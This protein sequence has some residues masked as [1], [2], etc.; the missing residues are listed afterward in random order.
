MGAIGTP[1]L[2]SWEERPTT[3]GHIAHQF[4][5]SHTMTLKQFSLV[6]KINKSI[7]FKTAKIVFKL[8]TQ[9]KII[10]NKIMLKLKKKQKKQKGQ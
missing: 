8:I 6:C 3:F 9:L 5:L 2:H 7:I 4:T 1:G 10:K